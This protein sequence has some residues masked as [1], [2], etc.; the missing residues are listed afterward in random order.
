MHIN[1]LK[2]QQLARILLAD[3]T[4]YPLI[5]K[6]RSI[7]TVFYNDKPEVIVHLKP[8]FK[9]CLNINEQR[10]DIIHGTWFVGWG[11]QNQEEFNIAS[12][13]KDKITAKGVDLNILSYEHTDFDELTKKIIVAENLILKTK[14]LF[15]WWP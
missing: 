1:G 11:E 10:N 4:A 6:L 15:G 3:Q 13:R 8:L 2:D 5:A 14:W 7:V 9:F 12:G